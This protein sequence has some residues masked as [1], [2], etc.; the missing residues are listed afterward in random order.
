MALPTIFQ[1]N[2]QCPNKVA[3][4][5]CAMIFVNGFV[6]CIIAYI[7]S[8]DCRYSINAEFNSWIGNVIVSITVSVGRVFFCDMACV[9]VVIASIPRC[10]V[11]L[12]NSEC[13]SLNRF[14][15]CGI[16]FLDG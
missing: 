6:A 15:Q 3:V 4:P 11:L 8:T 2:N 9:S 10:G 1:N 14:D 7:E 13:S 16:Q 5:D 12:E